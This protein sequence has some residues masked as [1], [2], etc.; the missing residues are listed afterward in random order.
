MAT[1]EMESGH[2][3]AV[4]VMCSIKQRVKKLVRGKEVKSGHEARHVL[5]I[6]RGV[7]RRN[8]DAGAVVMEYSINR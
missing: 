3:A 5:D 1:L 2:T 7:L 8:G 6:R 4:E